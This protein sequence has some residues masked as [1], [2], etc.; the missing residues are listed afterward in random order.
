MIL[1]G[2]SDAHKRTCG[3]RTCGLVTTVLGLLTSVAFVGCATPPTTSKTT[4]DSTAQIRRLRS[5]IRKQNQVIQ[6]LKEKNLVL[7][8]RDVLNASTK[9]ELADAETPTQLP[10]SFDAKELAN[11]AA[12][13]GGESI[14]G[15]HAA[16]KV[17]LPTALPTKL[18]TRTVAAAAPAPAAVPQA[19]AAPA[20]APQ[21][22]ISVSPAKTGEHFLYSKILETYRSRNEDEMQK[23]L[24]LLLKTYPES[25]FAD[26]ALYMSGLMAFES[27]NTTLAQKQ[28]ER[29]LKEYPRS[30]KAVAALFAKAS[31]EKRQGRTATAKRGFMRVRDLYPGS[32]EAARVATELKLLEAAKSK[33]REM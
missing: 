28:F 24:Q 12:F 29:L 26:N 17:T 4:V 32:P 1:N 30:N 8:K 3:S 31:I 16:P 27:G 14:G 7:E 11:A 13:D 22:P 5:Q 33:S 19:L 2:S 20:P 25:V 23:T 15:P 6:D 21:A 18:P 9:P 10:G